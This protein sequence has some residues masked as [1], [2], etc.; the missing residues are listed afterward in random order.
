MNSI[1]IENY[2]TLLRAGAFNSKNNEI[3]PMS[4]HKWRILGNMAKEHHVQNFLADGMALIKDSDPNNAEKLPE[5]ND[6]GMTTY[7]KYEVEGGFDASKAYLVNS[8]S[9][10]RWEEL[11]EGEMNDIN[12][13][14]DE[15][16]QL[17]DIIIMNADYA[18]DTQINVEGILFLGRFLQMNKGL[19]NST[20]LNHWLTQTKMSTMANMLG[21]ILTEVFDFPQEEIP[22]LTK[23]YNKAENLFMETL[24]NTFDKR[25]IPL[26]TCMRL[27]TLE[28]I[29]CRFSGAISIVRDVEE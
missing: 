2:I 16:L 20:K 17:L 10:R 9:K 5:L 11:R 25:R 7:T 27:A 28:T 6:L 21:T 1:I 23:P 13:I 3:L 12:N 15:T 8:I 14:S 22:F 18:I 4:L 26:L 19:I 29:N 24:E